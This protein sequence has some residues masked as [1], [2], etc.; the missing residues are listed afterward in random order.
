MLRG[1]HTKQR[2][3]QDRLRELLSFDPEAGV[4]TWRVNRGGKARAGSVAGTPDKHGYICIH[5]DCGLYKAHRL[6]WLY[7]NGEWPVGEIDHADGN[8]SN[9]AIANLRAADRTKQNRNRKI[10]KTNRLGLKGVRKFGARFEA[11]IKV[12]YRKIVIG[13]YD[14]PE[15]AHSA[16]VREANRLFGEFARAA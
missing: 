13:V 4:F 16:Y 8:P 1:V 15:E 12:N 10:N 14:T 9:N 2:P 5:I 3:S 6:A 7:V 11:R